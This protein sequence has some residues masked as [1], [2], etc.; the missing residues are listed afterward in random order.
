MDPP[1]PNSCQESIFSW[2]STNLSSFYKLDFRWLACSPCRNANLLVVGVNRLQQQRG[3]EDY[4][5]YLSLLDVGPVAVI[6]DNMFPISRPIPEGLVTRWLPQD[7]ASLYRCV[8]NR[9]GGTYHQKWWWFSFLNCMAFWH[10]QGAIFRKQSFV[11][12]Y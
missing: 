4:T 2:H 5:M 12:F 6:H 1:S 3:Q 9:V 8:R 7:G 11:M 10:D